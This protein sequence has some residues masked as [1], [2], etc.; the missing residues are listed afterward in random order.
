MRIEY[1]AMDVPLEARLLEKTATVREGVPY[2]ELRWTGDT[3]LGRWPAKAFV[4]EG[5]R[6]DEVAL[7]YYCV[8]AT[9]IE[10]QLVVLEYEG[11]SERWPRAEEMMRQFSYSVRLA[12]L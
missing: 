6:G 1:R 8:L 7:T 2:A 10:Q 11:P 4:I 9:P 12:G 3:T 5:Q